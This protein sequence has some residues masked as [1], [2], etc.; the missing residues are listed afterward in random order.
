MRRF[1]K[2]DKVADLLKH[3]ISN[4]LLTELGDERLRWIT[5]NAVDLTRDISLAKVYYTVLEPALGR[6]QAVE[7]LKENLKPLRRFLASKLRLRQLPEIHFLY[8]ETVDRARRIE[9]LLGQVQV[10]KE[11]A[12]DGEDGDD[13]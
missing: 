4:A 5:V 13:T 3:A 2:S 6:E 11:A 12:E 10:R 8:D 1:A 7:A 9:D